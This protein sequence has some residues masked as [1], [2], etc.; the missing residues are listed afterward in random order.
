MVYVQLPH[1]FI[2]GLECPWIWI[3]GC[4]V[5]NSPWIPRHE[6]SNIIPANLKGFSEQKTKPMTMKNMLNNLFFC[7]ASISIGMKMWIHSNV[8]L[9]V[10][11]HS[12]T[13]VYCNDNS[14]CGKLKGN[15][16]LLFF[17]FCMSESPTEALRKQLCTGVPPGQ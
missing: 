10:T 14:Y 1:H 8:I 15:K 13:R 11:S 17:L 7:N 16:T 3:L 9:C 12:K 6:C 5:T 4:L 2:Y